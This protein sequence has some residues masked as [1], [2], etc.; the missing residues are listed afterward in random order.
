MSDDHG[1]G[2]CNVGDEAFRAAVA[3]MMAPAS[4]VMSIRTLFFRRDLLDV[5]RNP[6]AAQVNA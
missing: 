2:H 6:A 3:T 5:V 1:A 4:V